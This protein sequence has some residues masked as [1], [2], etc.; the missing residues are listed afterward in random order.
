MLC[1]KVWRG[2]ISVMHH[3]TPVT[4]KYGGGQ[5]YIGSLGPYMGDWQQQVC[6]TLLDQADIINGRKIDIVGGDF[7][8]ES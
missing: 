7:D 4:V 6:L 5:A 2:S 8:S 1:V 3:P